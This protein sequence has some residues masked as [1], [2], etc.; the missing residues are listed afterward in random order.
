MANMMG[1]HKIDKLPEQRHR[2]IY[3]DVLETVAKTADMYALD[4]ND[5]KRTQSLTVTLRN[6]AKKLGLPVKVI[7]RNTTI[8]VVRTSPLTT[9]VPDGLVPEE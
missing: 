6:R 8:C 1:F 9:E 5:V 7:V 4:T 2:G 3:D